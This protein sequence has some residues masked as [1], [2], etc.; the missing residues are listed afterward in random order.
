MK[1]LLLLLFIPI[2]FY[3]Q[4]LTVDDE[5]VNPK[6]LIPDIKIDL[7]YASASHKFTNTPDGDIPLPKFY[8]ANECLILLKAAK[9]LAV[10]QD[11]LRK[12]RHF[13]GKDYPKGIG[14]KIWDGYRPHTVQYLFWDIYPNST[15]I[16]PPSGGSMHNRGGAMDVT[17]I[18]LATGKELEM[19][20]VFDD[21]STAASHSNYDLPQNVINKRQL[22]KDVMCKVA[23]FSYYE[24][25][26]W[27]YNVPG[28]GNY[29]LLDFQLK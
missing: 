9:M 24:G 20:T 5:M 29:P 23:G 27:H 21:F 2:I 1:K 26:W 4:N 19:P 6:E 28:A 25:E 22:L 3:A 12:I 17:L 15:Y 14:I 7:R 16:A 8:T 13:N 18:D 10:A 11:S